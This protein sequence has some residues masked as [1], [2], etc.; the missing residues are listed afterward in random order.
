MCNPGQ[1]LLGFG[2]GQG[3]RKRRGLNLTAKASQLV[4]NVRNVFL[5][6][7]FAQQLL[8]VLAC[9]TTKDQDV[10][11]LGANHLL[12][13]Y[14]DSRKKE[15]LLINHG[16]PYPADLTNASN[17]V[18]ITSFDSHLITSFSLSKPNHIIFYEP[19]NPTLLSAGGIEVKIAK[20]SSFLSK[21][22]LT[23]CNEAAHNANR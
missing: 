14:P 11:V 9:D 3:R 12:V 4:A 19:T 13:I 8:N 20:A 17:Q 21:T 18:F 10:L 22:S 1:R 2:V 5:I 7:C 15:P 23:N 16:V 6:L